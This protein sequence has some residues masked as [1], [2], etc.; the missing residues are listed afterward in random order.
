[1]GVSDAQ[2]GKLIVVSSLSL[3]VYY[4]LWLWVPPFISKSTLES[5]PYI[6]PPTR[7]ALLVPALSGMLFIGGLLVFTINALQNA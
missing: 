5:F 6:F 4:T 7:Y 2:L 3:F 1:M